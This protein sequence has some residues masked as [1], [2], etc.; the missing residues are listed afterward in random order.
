VDKHGA[1]TAVEIEHRPTTLKRGDLFLEGVRRFFRPSTRT[2]LDTPALP[3]GASGTHVDGHGVVWTVGRP[4]DGQTVVYSA[5]P[6]A[7]WTKH[8]V[9]AYSNWRH[10]CVCDIGPRPRGRCSVLVVTGDHWQHVSTDYGRTWT[11]YDLSTTDPYRVVIEGGRYPIVS[12]LA[13]G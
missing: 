3:S 8:L 5:K 2:L 10:G 6:G 1:E 13:D 7:R 12:A 11:T 4:E 9:G